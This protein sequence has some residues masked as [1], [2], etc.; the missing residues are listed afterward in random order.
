MPLSSMTGYARAQGQFE[1]RTWTWEVRSVNGRGLE[2]RCRVPPGF[3]SLDLASRKRISD[4]FSRGNI[5]VTLTVIR[6]GGGVAVRV[7]T[8]VLERLLTLATDLQ[9][10]LPDASAPSIDGLLG[11]RG[12]IEAAEEELSEDARTA[13]EAV[14]LAGLDE[15]AGAL[16]AMRS[17]EGARIESVLADHLTRIGD[18]AVAAGEL[19]AAQ[20]QAVLARLKEQLSAL[21]TAAPPLTEERLAQEAALLAARADPRE[22]ID[23]LAAHVAA[24]RALTVSTAPAGRKLD[25]LCQELNREANTL[26]SKSADVDLTR[27]GLDLK[28]A[29]EQFR[30]QVQNIE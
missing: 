6:A 27:I 28:A 26:C 9:K 1:D 19:A 11:L 2:V 3:E 22:E 24:A 17:E 10:R 16:A 30:E 7:N 12:V 8:E 13:F 29:I 20:P 18:L 15:A 4:R 23:R 25:F 5:S 21:L 14:L